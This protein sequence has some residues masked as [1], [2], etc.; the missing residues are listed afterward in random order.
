MAI[1]LTPK[2]EEL[3]H[4]LMSSGRYSEPEE[5]V[6]AALKNLNSATISSLINQPS[7]SLFGCLKNQIKIQGDL[8]N[9][10]FSG[11]WEMLQ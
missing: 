4:S 6:D 11:S 9:V 3:V 1:T 2:Q 8:E 7:K 5:V 10:D